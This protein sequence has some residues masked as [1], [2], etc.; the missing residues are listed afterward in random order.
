MGNVDA[1][2]VQGWQEQFDQMIL[3]VDGCFGRRDLRSRASRYIRGLLGSVQRKNS[4][5][6]AEQ[7]GD[8]TPHGIQRLLGR[9]R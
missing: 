5:Q 2:A 9:A 4:W 3:R 7:V 6:L 1:L 8:A